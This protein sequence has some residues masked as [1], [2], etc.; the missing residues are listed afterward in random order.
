MHILITN[1]VGQVKHHHTCAPFLTL[2]DASTSLHGK[3]YLS[4]EVTLLWFLGVGRD[5]LGQEPGALCSQ[6]LKV[7]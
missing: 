4:T 1:K 7:T 5:R 3:L 6:A 2:H